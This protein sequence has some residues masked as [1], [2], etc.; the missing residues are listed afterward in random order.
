MS[1]KSLFGTV[2]CVAT[3]GGAALAVEASDFTIID[4]DASGG[5]SL[6]E[7]LAV[8]PDVTEDEFVNFDIDGSGELSEAEYEE[9]QASRTND[10]TPEEDVDDSE[11]DDTAEAN[12]IKDGDDTQG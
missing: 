12:T 5:L 4:A 8:A 6:A 2:I 7:V 10:D 9:W 11:E 3:I 1:I